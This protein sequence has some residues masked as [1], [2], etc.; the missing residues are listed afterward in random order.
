MAFDPGCSQDYLFF[1]PAHGRVTVY[2][3]A[4]L[5]CCSMKTNSVD[6]NKGYNH[7]DADKKVNLA[8]TFKN[9]PGY[10]Y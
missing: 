10:L 3:Q 4:T 6:S 1:D 2:L 9:F 7:Q 8:R 5:K